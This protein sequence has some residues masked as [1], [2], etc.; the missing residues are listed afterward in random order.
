MKEEDV[1]KHSDFERELI[2]KIHSAHALGID[3]EKTVEMLLRG[4]VTGAIAHEYSEEKIMG[5]I[6]SQIEH[7]KE[8]LKMASDFGKLFEVLAKF[9]ET[10]N[11]K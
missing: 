9:V 10:N 2:L 1:K 8:S 11:D 4:F 7:T 6:K 5:M 3:S